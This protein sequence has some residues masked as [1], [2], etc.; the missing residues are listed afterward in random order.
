ME[1]V[2]WDMTA[3]DM[4]GWHGFETT[5][6]CAAGGEPSAVWG[7]ESYT[8]D[9][10]ICMAAVHA[11]LISFQDGGSVTIEITPG[12]DEYGGGLR[13]GVETASYGSWVGSFRFVQ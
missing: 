12:L 7:S 9:S 4:R 11:G 10:S 6:S 3:I 8:D 1:A 2:T 5:V 13:H